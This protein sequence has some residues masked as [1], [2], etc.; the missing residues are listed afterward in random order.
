M[1]RYSDEGW[2][3]QGRRNKRAGE[4]DILLAAVAETTAQPFLVLTSDL[5]VEYANR[6]FYATFKVTERETLD[7]PLLELGNRQWDIPELHALLAEVLP[8]HENVQNFR[9]QHDFE[10]IGYR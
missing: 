2:S 1:Q 5:R 6:A 4:L 3:R 9:V 7:R 10:I 8:K